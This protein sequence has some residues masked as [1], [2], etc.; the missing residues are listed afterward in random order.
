[1]TYFDLFCQKGKN[2]AV[3]CREKAEDAAKRRSC[4]LFITWIP[5]YN[6]MR[7]EEKRKEV[8]SM[9]RLMDVLLQYAYMAVLG[10]QLLLTGM[11]LHVAYSVR[12][13][14]RSILEI[15]NKVASYLEVILEDTEE[16]AKKPHRIP[17]QEELMRASI[18][19]RK[20]QQQEA[21]FEAVLKEIFP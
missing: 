4:P 13:A 6:D 19:N 10:L 18:E 14:N 11:L 16:E 1:M 21:V 12:K 5:V 2:A 9:E 8:M 7:K 17:K 15:R 3:F 20:K